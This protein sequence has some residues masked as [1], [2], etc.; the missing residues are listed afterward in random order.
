MSCIGRYGL[1]ITS[2]L[3]V[4]GVIISTSSPNWIATI[5]DNPA[6]GITLETE[7]GPFYSRNRTCPTAGS[8]DDCTDWEQHGIKKEDCDAFTTISLAETGGLTEL[9]AKE[10]ICR[11]NTAW[12]ALAELCFFIVVGTA[13]LVAAATFTQ[14]L[15]CGCCGGSFDQLAMVLCYIEVILSIACW[16]IVISVVTMIRGE[17][18]QTIVVEEYE[19]LSQISNVTD[20]ESALNNVSQGNFLWGFWL[21]MISGTHYE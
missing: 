14:C 2:V 15:T 12:R 18:F 10:D 9:E 16:S 4:S 17:D 19:T 13:I 3:F 20:I 6:T 1:M 5:V 8:E 11:Q 21:F 7:Y